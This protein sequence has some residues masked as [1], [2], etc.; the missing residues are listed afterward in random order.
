MYKAGRGNVDQLLFTT[1]KFSIIYF[2]NFSSLV[3][4]RFSALA[5]LGVHIFQVPLFSCSSRRYRDSSRCF[6][7]VLEAKNEGGVDSKYAGLVKEST[8]SGSA[9]GLI[10]EAWYSSTWHR[11]SSRSSALRLI[12]PTNSV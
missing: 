12:H 3:P 4:S 6:V 2:I 1:N 7:Q 5:S 11:P 10:H 9:G 8:L